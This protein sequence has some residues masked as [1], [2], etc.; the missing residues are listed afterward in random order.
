MKV[1]VIGAGAWGTALASLATSGA[2]TR[3]WAREPEVAEM[4]RRDHENHMFLPGF[5]L[6]DDLIVTNDLEEAL[7]D[8]DLAVVAVPS[9]HLR[10]TVAAARAFLSDRAVV[11]SVAKGIE[12]G[13]H[14]RMTEVLSEEL[15]DATPDS[16]GVLSGPNLAR[17]VMAGQPS[18]TCVAFSEHRGRG[19]WSRRLDGRHIVGTRTEE[20]L[21]PRR[22]RRGHGVRPSWVSDRAYL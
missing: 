15:V 18:A 5:R 13:S 16:I 2:E 3:L 6:P 1:G 9:Q 11:V 22:R 10:S 21:D 19:H 4:I 14:Q 7:R 12:L 17:E 8:V 20:L